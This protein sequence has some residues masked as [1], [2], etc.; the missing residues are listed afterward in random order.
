MDRSQGLGRSIG[1]IAPAGLGRRCAFAASLA[2]SDLEWLVSYGRL[3]NGEREIVVRACAP[4]TSGTEITMTDQ[5]QEKEQS[6]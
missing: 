3:A 1:R 2:E 5:G 4:V 6:A